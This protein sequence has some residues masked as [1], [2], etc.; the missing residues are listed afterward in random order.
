ELVPKTTS[1]APGSVASDFLG[2]STFSFSVLSDR[3]LAQLGTQLSV[4]STIKAPK[5][6][7]CPYGLA[8]GIYGKSQKVFDTIVAP[9]AVNGLGSPLVTVNTTIEILPV[10]TDQAATDLAAAVNP[11]LAAVPQSSS[12][13]IKDV[14]L[15]SASNQT[16]AWCKALFG[17]R[18]I[19]IGIS[20]PAGGSTSTPSLSQM[21]DGVVDVAQL[22]TL[23]GFGAS[24]KINVVYPQ[25][26]PQ[27]KVE[28]GYFHSDFLIE[29]VT[30]MAFEL[31][32]GIKFYPQDQGTDINGQLVLSRGPL[33]SSK[34]Q[35]MA[36]ALFDNTVPPAV[37]D[38][39]GIKLGTSATQTIV[40]FS[41]I[42]YEIPA[43]SLSGSSAT[44]L[45]AGMAKV[46]GAD[47]AV[48]SPSDVGI[49][50]SLTLNN[51]Y[52]V[53]LKTGAIKLQTLLDNQNVIGLAVSPLD[54]SAGSSSQSLHF[55]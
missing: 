22:D 51:P 46:S 18:V 54:I 25:G 13:G 9:V 27:I 44:S 50:V 41:K 1:A 33:V 15:V 34:L 55:A 36:N 35:S 12:I 52:P 20:A 42:L 40:T 26:M 49:S 24:G 48:H 10:N 14:S 47:V 6:F 17:D 38:V 21:I 37:L 29:N 11:L 3:L 39:S 32:S 28:L 4:A 23:P 31:P 16:F 7:S 53:S 5:E 45:P 43:S 19:E 8:L 30:L 2:N